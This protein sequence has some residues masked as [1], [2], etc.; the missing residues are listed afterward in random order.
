MDVSL[1]LQIAAFIGKFL[2][3]HSSPHRHLSHSAEC[4]VQNLLFHVID[5]LDIC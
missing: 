5:V 2:L 4:I 1:K 3:V